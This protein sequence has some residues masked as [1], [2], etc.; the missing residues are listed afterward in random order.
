[1]ILNGLFIK[2]SNITGA[3]PAVHV[4]TGA[5]PSSPVTHLRMTYMYLKQKRGMEC[6]VKTG[7]TLPFPNP[8]TKSMVQLCLFEV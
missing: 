6:G 4:W 1:M 7:K 2:P 5:C 8:A 3:N